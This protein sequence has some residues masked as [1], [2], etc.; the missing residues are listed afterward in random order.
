MSSP[1]SGL[2]SIPADV[3]RGSFAAG[4]DRSYNERA[5]SVAAAPTALARPWCRCIFGQPVTIPNEPLERCVEGLQ[6]DAYGLAALAVAFAGVVIALASA[7]AARRSARAAEKAERAAET[8][9]V[10]VETS[11]EFARDALRRAQESES[12]RARAV[13][14][15]LTAQIRTEHTRATELA[16]SLLTARRGASIVFGSSD[17]GDREIARVEAIPDE[18]KTCI[19]RIESQDLGPE[20]LAQ[21]SSEK[22]E[23]LAADLRSDLSRLQNKADAMAEE[24]RGLE[25]RLR[26]ELLLRG[27]GRQSPP[28]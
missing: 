3:S 22:L 27:L 13:V 11:V 6:M 26:E 19:G 2:E 9:A 15:G 4:R 10:A 28:S 18:L 21:L 20:A 14:A 16:E 25:T 5:R 24:L 8:S 23:D 12:R 7:R 1:D 17:R